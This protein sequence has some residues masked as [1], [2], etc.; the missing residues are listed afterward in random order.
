VISARPFIFS[1]GNRNIKIRGRSYRLD[2][3]GSKVGT[4]GR[5]V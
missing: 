2:G 4:F 5:W 3:I 1:K